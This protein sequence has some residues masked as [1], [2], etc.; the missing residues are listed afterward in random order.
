MK[1][2]PVQQMPT[3]TT[4]ATALAKPAKTAKPK[5]NAMTALFGQKRQKSAVANV[6]TKTPAF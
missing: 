1:P 3:Q 4:S 5:Q 2:I 6:P